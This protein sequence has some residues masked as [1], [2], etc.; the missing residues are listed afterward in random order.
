MQQSQARDGD[1][2]RRPPEP[3]ADTDALNIIS[4]ELQS[5]MQGSRAKAGVFLHKPSRKVVNLRL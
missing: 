3:P 1:V 4:K 2:A 5:S